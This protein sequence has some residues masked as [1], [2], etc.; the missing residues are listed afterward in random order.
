M[1]EYNNKIVKQFSKFIFPFRY[2]AI[3]TDLKSKVYV[4]DKGTEINIFNQFSQDAREL[5]QGL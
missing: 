4:N 2:D 1:N 5:L 3:R